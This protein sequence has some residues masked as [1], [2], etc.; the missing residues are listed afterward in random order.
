M[1][2][3]VGETT[4]GKGRPGLRMRC[5]VPAWHL[6]WQSGEEPQEPPRGGEVLG[7]LFKQKET[8]LPWPK[9]LKATLGV[10]SCGCSVH[11]PDSVSCGP[12]VS[13]QSC[14]CSHIAS[15]L[16]LQ[17]LPSPWVCNPSLLLSLSRFTVSLPD[18]LLCTRPPA[19]PLGTPGASHVLAQEEGVADL[20]LVWKKTLRFS[21]LHCIQRNWSFYSLKD[22]GMPFVAGSFAL[23]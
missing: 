19:L 23:S 22:R 8:H 14:Y 16:L 6:S 15:R 5:G 17:L 18:W 1:F 2:K 7:S 9:K 12:E 4:V 3:E 20:D 11:G 13:M 10:L 21:D